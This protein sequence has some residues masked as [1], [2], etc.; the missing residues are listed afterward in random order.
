MNKH[1]LWLLGGLGACQEPLQLAPEVALNHQHDAAVQQQVQ[2]LQTKHV[3]LSAA[4]VGAQGAPISVLQ[5]EVLNPQ[6]QPEQ[7]DTLRQRVRKLAQLLVTD[8]TYPDR[9]KVM[10]V[11]VIF[12]KGPFSPSSSVRSLSFIY[13]VASLR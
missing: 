13:P 5:L 4:P 1:W 9:Y 6:D 7:P 12:R 8:L 11:Q 2:R 10:N 3:K